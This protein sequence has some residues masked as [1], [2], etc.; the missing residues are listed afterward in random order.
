MT[1][2]LQIQHDEEEAKA[3]STA[4]V[5]RG[6]VDVPVV[7]NTPKPLKRAKRIVNKG[8]IL[9]CVWSSLSLHQCLR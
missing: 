8:P 2:A 7:T 1:A 4:L 5:K 3:S 9:L 6:E